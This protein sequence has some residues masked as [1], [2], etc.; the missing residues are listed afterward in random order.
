M[1][2]ARGV[3]EIEGGTEET[4]EGIV[5][6]NPTRKGPILPSAEP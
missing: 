3:D 5:Q 4:G 2:G 6:C 1:G